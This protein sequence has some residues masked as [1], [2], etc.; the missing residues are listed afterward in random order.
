MQGQARRQK[1]RRSTCR[2]RL[3][4]ASRDIRTPDPQPASRGAPS[5]RNQQEFCPCRP[6]FCQ[7]SPLPCARARETRWRRRLPWGGCPGSSFAATWI[8]RK[9]PPVVFR[10]PCTR[11]RLMRWPMAGT[12]QLGT[13]GSTWMTAGR[14]RTLLATPTR[15]I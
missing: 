11:L 14:T 7:L 3:F 15:A 4:L 5:T 13:L 2:A 6:S 9:T 8:A 10:K 12:S 1:G